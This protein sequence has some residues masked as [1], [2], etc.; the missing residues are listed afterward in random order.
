M[1]VSVDVR[2]YSIRELHDDFQRENVEEN[3]RKSPVHD[4]K[5]D[6]APRRAIQLQQLVASKYDGKSK[7]GGQVL[8]FLRGCFALTQQGRSVWACFY[9][10]PAANVRKRTAFTGAFALAASLP[11]SF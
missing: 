7:Y 4:G 10:P 9:K 11:F 1:P 5:R 3:N 8:S 6:L 2:S